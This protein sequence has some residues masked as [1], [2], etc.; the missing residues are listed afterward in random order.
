MPATYRQRAQRGPC[1][2][3]ALVALTWLPS[4]A[5]SDPGVSETS[6]RI[7]RQADI[8]KTSY[9]LISHRSRFH[10]C[11]NRLLCLT[12]MRCLHHEYRRGP[13][14]GEGTKHPYPSLIVASTCHPLARR[15]AFI[16]LQSRRQGVN[17]PLSR[18]RRSC[19]SLEDPEATGYCGDL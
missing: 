13:R 10:G 5:C 7:Q 2:K 3:P 18:Y 4:P 12:K 8:S 14:A 17:Y 6:W 1:V 11:H 15:S 19:L 16:G 9:E